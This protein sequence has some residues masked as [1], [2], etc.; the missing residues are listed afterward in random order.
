MSENKLWHT[1][2]EPQLQDLNQTDFDAAFFK[3]HSQTISS[4]RQRAALNLQ[5][6]FSSTCA[7]QTSLSIL[8]C[9][10][11]L[12]HHYHLACAS[13]MQL[14]ISLH[15]LQSFWIQPI[16]VAAFHLQA[17]LNPAI[18]SRSFAS[19]TV[20]TVS[21]ADGPLLRF[22]LRPSVRVLTFSFVTSSFYN[23]KF[24]RVSVTFYFKLGRIKDPKFSKFKNV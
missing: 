17:S 14:A 18:S 9:T 11:W 2:R 20:F 24:Q 16:F 21:T 22:S 5:L 6:F 8:I 15:A 7:P 4:S 13:S 23:R 12:C 1:A 3:W 19:L 10:V